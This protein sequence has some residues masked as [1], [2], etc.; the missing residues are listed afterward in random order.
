VPS[1]FPRPSDWCFAASVSFTSMM[2]LLRTLPGRFGSGPE[3]EPILF[4]ISAAEQG[5][6]GRAKG[7]RT[8]G[9]FE[10]DIAWKDGRLKAATVLST[11]G[12][13]PVVRS[14]PKVASIR[15]H[16]WYSC[17]LDANLAVR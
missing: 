15:L 14:G 6:T 7:L 4:A 5:S 3:H 13:N 2:V 11:A 17:T 1:H 10:V 16:A 12:K 8:R 9:G